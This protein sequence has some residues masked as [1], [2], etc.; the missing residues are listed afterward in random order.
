MKL[1]F[2]PTLSFIQ[3]G[4]KPFIRI[5]VLLSFLVS[6][7]V[8]AV[9]FIVNQLKNYEFKKNNEISKC[10]KNTKDKH[11]AHEVCL[12]LK[13]HPIIVGLVGGTGSH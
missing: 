7:K 6:G 2:P 5:S 9:P 4:G 3:P 13:G 11:T 10:A 12:D 1:T 8:L